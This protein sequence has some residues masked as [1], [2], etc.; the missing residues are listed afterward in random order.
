MLWDHRLR[1]GDGGDIQNRVKPVV[2]LRDG[3]VDDRSVR[4]KDN[5]MAI[6]GL[7]VPLKATARVL[8]HR[9]TGLKASARISKFLDDRPGLQDRIVASSGAAESAAQGITDE[10]VMELRRRLAELFGADLADGP[11]LTE[12]C[13]LLLEAWCAA[14]NDLDVHVLRWLRVGAPAWVLH[15][16]EAAG[17]FPVVDEPPYWGVSV[18]GAST[19]DE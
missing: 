9:I 4:Q 18:S 5:D 2:K 6:G 19:G 1:T 8:G 12:I 7:R 14:A 11:G 16:P 13:A 15:I 3:G 17:I 10:E